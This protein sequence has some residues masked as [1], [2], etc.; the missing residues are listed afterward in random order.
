[1]KNTIK[2]RQFCADEKV[3]SSG[4]SPANQTAT[5]KPVPMSWRSKIILWIGAWNELRTTRRLLR[6]LSDTQL[7]DI[8]LTR[9][10]IHEEYERKVWPHWPK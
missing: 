7:K 6:R 10:D 2:E 9:Q 1:M 4:F 3:V 8:G 5:I